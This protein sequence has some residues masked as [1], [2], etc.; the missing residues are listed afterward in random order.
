[1]PRLV[2]RIEH[3][4][5]TVTLSRPQL[6]NA[7]DETLIAEL[8]R[9]LGEL[10]ADPAVRVVVL[11]AAGKSFSAGADLNWMRR[12]AACDE[13]HNNADALALA[14]LLD[15]LYRLPKPT[16]AAVQGHALGG[17]A[18]LVCCCDLA[19]GVE[20]AQFGFSEVLLGLIPAVIAPYVLRA[21]GARAARRWFLS[22]E[23]F[24]AAEAHRIG[25]LHRVVASDALTATVDEQCAA[26][27]KAAPQAQRE[28]KELLDTLDGRSLTGA[29]AGGER[30]A[31]IERRA[32]TELCAAWIA[33]LRA[34]PEG[35]AG[36]AAFLEKKAPPWVR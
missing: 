25:L 7:F 36:I 30:K 29:G 28:T 1:M 4:V 2:S 35:R 6:H 27:L 3:K 32:V 18:G 5:A 31:T 34:S 10:G 16:V 20:S 21:I 14:A 23:R 8:Q 33:R 12:A 13:A 24:G 15:T 19:I 11:G 22:G 9:V 17:G 26:L